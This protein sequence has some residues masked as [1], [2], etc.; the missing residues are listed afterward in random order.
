M[1][2]HLDGGRVKINIRPY[3]KIHAFPESYTLF[4]VNRAFSYIH[5]W[6]DINTL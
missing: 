5:I 2:T 6:S 4:Y 1:C 3:E